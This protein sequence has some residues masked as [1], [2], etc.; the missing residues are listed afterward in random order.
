MQSGGLHL[1]GAA[2]TLACLFAGTEAFF[3]PALISSFAPSLGLERLGVKRN[4]CVGAVAASNHAVGE[5][6]QEL[7]GCRQSPLP[8]TRS[9]HTHTHTR[10]HTHTQIR[11][12]GR[13][14]FTR[15]LVSELLGSVLFC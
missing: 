8:P 11:A 4:I 9:T 13:P 2:L 10:T 6:E 15:I 5:E 3:A 12:Q 1:A 14:C 7:L